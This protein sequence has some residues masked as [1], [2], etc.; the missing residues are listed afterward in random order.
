ML[1]SDSG[2]RGVRFL[3]AAFSLLSCSTAIAQSG[4]ASGEV[5]AG[6]ARNGIARVP[7]SRSTLVFTQVLPRILVGQSFQ[8]TVGQLKGQVFVPHADSVTWQSSDAG[9]VSV[10]R[11][12][13]ITGIVQGRAV[14]TAAAPYGKLHIRVSVVSPLR[15]ELVASLEITPDTNAVDAGSTIQLRGNA[16]AADGVILAGA[17]IGWSSSDTA[18]LRV[19]DDGLL[20]ARKEGAARVLATVGHL[21]QEMSVRVDKSTISNFSITPSVISLAPGDSTTVVAA[22]KWR[23]GSSVDAADMM[24]TARRGRVRGTTYTAPAGVALDSIFARTTD[25]TWTSSVVRIIGVTET[26]VAAQKIDLHLLRFDGGSGAVLVS[27]GIP[28]AP[29]QLR[30]SDVSQTRLVVDGTEVPFSI[31]ALKGYHKDGSLRAVLLQATIAFGASGALAV[32][33]IGTPSTLTRPAMKPPVTDPVAMAIP[34]TAQLIASRIVG[35]TVPIDSTSLQNFDQLFKTNAD[36]QWAASGSDWSAT[37]YYDRVLNHVGYWVRG[38]GVTYLRRAMSI[39]VDYREK[40]L[41]ANQ[42]GSSPHWA[43]LEGLAMHYWL[44]GDEASRQAV[45]RTTDR[46]TAAFTSANMARAD[47]EWLDGRIQARLLLANSLSSAL[48]A[49]SS[50]AAKAS[51]YIGAIASTTNAD[52]SHSWPAFCGQQANYM[53]ALQNDALIKYSELVASD[54]R[55]PALMKRSL[56]Y[57]WQ[58]QWSSTGQAF[59]YISGPCATVNE[60]ELAPDLNMLFLSGFAWYAGQTQDASYRLRADQIA[61]GGLLHAWISPTKQFNQFYYDAFNYLAYRKF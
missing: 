44:T 18:V 10:T 55:I 35:P 33:Q 61:L 32:L 19:S 23:D 12:G 7:D 28:L 37:N 47:Y 5:P 36:V 8:I 40:Y 49:G 30:A 41:V 50:Y 46:L 2:P 54:A 14:I 53:A 3:A 15:N 16:R 1:V 11:D 45:I 43:Q 27:S 29:G 38:G 26:S 51:E 4:I 39:A 25:G 9:I 42:Y 21:T 57:L 48:D 22:A 58:K 20:R 24:V 56:D 6:T 52:G 31:A 17:K 34:S 60:A 59:R 13:L